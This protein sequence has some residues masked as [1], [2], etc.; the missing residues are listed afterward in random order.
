MAGEKTR[1]ARTCTNDVRRH[2]THETRRDAG[3]NGGTSIAHKEC[4]AL[5]PARLLSRVDGRRVPGAAELQ[6]CGAGGVDRLSLPGERDHLRR[7][8]AYGVEYLHERIPDERRNVGGRDR[9]SGKW[10]GGERPPREWRQ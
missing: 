4:C 10:N 9:V 7:H 3:V 8:A 6:R 1:K 2:L 5:G